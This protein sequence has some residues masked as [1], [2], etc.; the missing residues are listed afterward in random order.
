MNL[1]S[2]KN[3]I[4]TKDARIL[5]GYTSDYLARLARS[6]KIN[7][8]HSGHAWLIDESSLLQFI[9]KQRIRKIARS[10]TLTEIRTSEYLRGA[11]SP[12]K[13]SSKLTKEKYRSEFFDPY[14]NRLRSRALAGSAALAVLMVAY[15]GAVQTLPRVFTQAATVTEQ[16]GIGFSEIVSGVESHVAH[17][18]E[19]SRERVVAAIENVSKKAQNEP[20][21]V[22]VDW[23]ASPKLSQLALSIPETESHSQ[24]VAFRPQIRVASQESIVDIRVPKSA[25]TLSGIDDSESRLAN[26]VT[27]YG[28]LAFAVYNRGVYISAEHMLSVAALTRD[29]LA[30][31]PQIVTKVNLA[32]GSAIID[33]THALI[34]TD[35]ELMY[36]LAHAGPASARATAMI[37]GGLGDSLFTASEV[38]SINT[39][40]AYIQSSLALQRTGLHLA[41][42]APLPLGKGVRALAAVAGALT[43]PE[44]TALTTYSVLHDFF[45]TA[46]LTIAR[47]FSPPTPVAVVATSTPPRVVAT[48]PAPPAVVSSLPGSNVITSATSMTLRQSTYTTGISPFVLS[49]SLAALKIDILGTVAQMV[50][51]LYARTN[52][53]VYYRENHAAENS[54]ITEIGT[55]GVLGGGTGITVAPVYGQVLMGDGSGGYSLVATS[56]L[57]ITGSGGGSWGSIL[58]TLSSQSDLQTALDSKLPLANWY[59]TTTDGLR[60]GTNN[61]YF[62]NARAQGAISATYPLVDTAGVFS[63]A[64]GTTTSN[65]WGGTQ[66]FT[67]APVIASYSGL[68]GSN[69]GSL[70]QVATSSLTIGGT[71]GNVTGTVAVTNGGTG[72]TSFTGNLLHYGAFSQVGTTTFTP[73]GEFS[74]TGSMGALVGGTNSTLALATN[75]IALTKLAQIA[76]NT[77]LGNLTGATGN[78]SAIATS[79]L[80]GSA[81]TGGYVLQW[82][83]TTNG[84]V[85]AATST[86]SGTN[87]FTNSGANTYLTTGSNLGIGST[88]P[89]AQLS[90][91]PNGISGPAFVIGSSTG[92]SFVVTNAGLVGIG[93]ANPGA[94]LDVSLNNSTNNTVGIRSLTYGI[95]SEIGVQ[96]V[97]SRNGGNPNLM[98]GVLGM[99]ES[100]SN[101][102][103]GG[104]FWVGG[105]ERDMT[106]PAAAVR[107]DNAAL[108]ANNGSTGQSVFK[109]QVNNITRF[110]VS[111]VGTVGISTTSPTSVLTIAATS[112][113][114]SLSLFDI[115]SPTPSGVATSSVFLVDA[116]GKVGIATTTPWAQLSVNPNGISGPAFVIGSSTGTS[117]IVTNGGLVGIGTA[118]PQTA[119]DVSGVINITGTGSRIT[120]PTS[121]ATITFSDNGIINSTN[122]GLSLNSSLRVGSSVGVLTALAES[123][124]FVVQHI[125]RSNDLVTK[126]LNIIGQGARP[127]AITNIVGGTIKITGGAGATASAAAANGG[128]V[129]IDGGQGFGSGASGSILLG[130]VN[131]GNVGIGT[132]SPTSKLQIN[133]DLRLDGPSGFYSTISD[134]TGALDTNTVGTGGYQTWSLASSEKMRLNSTGFGI[135]ITPTAKLHVASDSGGASTGI[136]LQQIANNATAA[137]SYISTDF[138]IPTNGLIGQ[139][140]ATANNYSSSINLPASSVALFA[141]DASGSLVLGAAGTSGDMR[142]NTGGYGVANERLRITSSGNVGIGT[143]TPGTLLSLGNTGVNTVNISTTATSTFGSGIN[144]LTG[145][146]AVNGTCVSGGGAGGSGTV[147]SGTTGQFPYYAANGTTLSATSTLFLALS[148]N[149]GIG[150]TSPDSKFH[151][152]DATNIATSPVYTSPAAFKISEGN[153]TTALLFDSNQIESIGGDLHLNFRATGGTG[154]NITMVVGGGK[155]GVGSTTPYAKLSVTGSGTGSGVNFETTN[156]S[157]APLFRVRDDGI[158]SIYSSVGTTRDNRILSL[159][160]SN[161][162]GNYITFYG[163]ATN[164]ATMHIATNYW[165][166][167]GALALGTYTTPDTLTLLPSGN[168]GI[169][170]TTPWGQLSLNPNGITGPAF[171]IGSSTATKFIVT[172]A[173]NVGIGTTNPAGQF[174]VVDTAGVNLLRGVTVSQYGAGVQSPLMNFFKSR[175]TVASPAVVV[176]GDYAG[177][178]NFTQYSGASNLITAGF[179]AR[180]NGTVTTT[181]VPTELFFYTSGGANDT[182][183]YGNS[184]IRM[185]INAAGNVG[186]GSTTPGTLLSL[187]NTGANTVNISATATSTFGS[188]INVLTGCFAINGVCVAAGSGT[189][190]FTNSGASTYLST[191]SNLGIGSTTPWGQLS[192]NPSGITGP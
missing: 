35:A 97:G 6:G 147:G 171:V 116:N 190:Y 60:E 57:G 148:G 187:G 121:G 103:I 86:S 43:V 85:L 39:K 139:F 179:G 154:N 47:L 152:M 13:A 44:Q 108:I 65:T 79:T 12:T 100:A 19:A 59:A 22:T 129:L 26:F 144:I 69:N 111:G 78:V 101:Q 122:G 64:Y 169:G 54:G 176:T 177:V 75:G 136:K 41:Q 29:L 1:P 145:C 82:S 11:I 112:S 185:L 51:P 96:G 24:I 126:S 180:I 31:A 72:Q 155:V 151:V 21:S 77:I 48:T 133:G 146:F 62:S 119:L 67:S 114:S 73:S 87:Y 34:R 184:H 130:T 192:V 172:N 173:G 8:A 125:I 93:T 81:S 5:S 68:I 178:F 98:V 127:T 91:N 23:L 170:T 10:K 104:Y 52:Q 167:D 58:G 92:T 71:A 28:S 16:V 141:E 40:T 150:T 175:G 56:S 138:V 2:T 115:Q 38:A 83:N 37:I 124:D 120:L 156:S 174:E 135:G 80:Y 17:S 15:I 162:T 161:T 128:A 168:T 157:N 20:I 137:L 45:T 132:T 153:G 70:Y 25:Q 163:A 18:T 134:V 164:G 118:S 166:S 49:Q 99:G 110:I 50:N 102:G 165:S 27:Q 183:P 94:G 7:G 140:L 76:A 105:T 33:T 4:T 74:T 189:N 84:L 55:I 42:M 117:L 181:S 149:V 158:T 14:E 66:T 90:V 143:T 88:S 191:G 63:L 89:W 36:G 188:G 32:F 109:A 53:V 9:A 46:T 30:T 106:V 61:L 95:A 160:T 123:N 182:D 159:G 186:I 142:F 107:T 113:A 131:A 3:L